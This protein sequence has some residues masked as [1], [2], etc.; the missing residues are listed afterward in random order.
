MPNSDETS[1]LE[2]WDYYGVTQEQ[3][4]KVL[5]GQR[6]SMLYLE[7]KLMRKGQP[8]PLLQGR[9]DATQPGQFLMAPGFEVLDG[10]GNAYRSW[11][12]VPNQT[13]DD[14]DTIGVTKHVGLV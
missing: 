7:I 14:L 1:E 9:F 4:D 2:T 6:S 12:F 11:L 5:K 3:L 10:N 8:V 13:L